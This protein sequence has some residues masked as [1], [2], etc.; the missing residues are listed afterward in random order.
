[1]YISIG[2]GHLDGQETSKVVENWELVSNALTVIYY[3]MT[4]VSKECEVLSC[5]PDL[6][7]DIVILGGIYPAL[8]S[9]YYVNCTETERTGV[10]KYALF[11]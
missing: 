5:C 9:P 8:N 7:N 10:A 1:M 4:T 2:S 6:Y 3:W 11:T